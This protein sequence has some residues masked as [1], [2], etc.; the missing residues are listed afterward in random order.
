MS[1]VPPRSF[2]VVFHFKIDVRKTCSSL[3][4]S[5]EGFTTRKYHN[6]TVFRKGKLTFTLFNKSGHVN[7]SGTKT[8]D[9]IGDTLAVAS[10]LF[11]VN[12]SPSDITV[13]SSTWSG[14]FAHTLLDIPSS[15]NIIYS[16]DK[17]IRVS[18]R[19]S[20]FP[21]AVIR[22]NQQPTVVVFRNAKYVVVG[23]TTDVA[24][25]DALQRIRPHLRC[26]C[27]C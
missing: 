20:R 16:S 1:E 24:V 7:S 5:K 21:G 26:Q 9:S 14:R 3:H 18:L 22:S 25:I 15:K 17:T 12:L 13:A 2:N 23:A 8:F 10:N 4:A 19:P 27:C 6:F 11:E